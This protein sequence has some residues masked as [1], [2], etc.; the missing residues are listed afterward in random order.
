MACFQEKYD[1]VNIVSQ[2]AEVYSAMYSSPLNQISADNESFTLANHPHAQMH[3][4]HVQGLFLEMLSFMIQ[5][6][7]ILEIGTFTGFSALSL[8]K[9]LKPGGCLHTIELRPEDASIAAEYF[10]KAGVSQKIK[11]HLG[12]AMVILPDLQQE[13]DL[14]FID[15]DKVNYINYYQLTLPFVKKGGFII[16]DNVLF[17]GQVFG[18]EVKGKNSK[19]IDAFNQYVASDNRVQQVIL[20]V[21]DGLSIIRKL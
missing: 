8:C 1:L 9:G 10:K 15:A 11:L 6:E 7:K 3:S 21:R 4:G 16:A 2:L 5:P 18:N 19:A 13:W 12:D 17:H 20:T 14:V